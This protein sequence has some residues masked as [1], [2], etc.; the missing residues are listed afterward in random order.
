MNE[1]NRRDFL[2]T[3]GRGAAAMA[4]SCAIPGMNLKS[5]KLNVL[6]IAVDDLRTE[7]GCYGNTRILSPNID[8]IA[9]EGILF[10]R[11]YCQEP[12]CMATR[13]SLLS[14]YRPSHS[15][16]YN[17]ESLDKLVP[18]ALTLNKYFAQKGYDIWASG[19]IYHHKVDHENQFGDQ[20]VTP[21]GKWE[22]RGYL[23]AEAIAQ[24]DQYAEEYEN[25]RGGESSGR[26][27]AFE[28]PDVPD[29]AYED[30]ARTELAI[31]QLEKFKQ[32][33]NPFFMAVGFKKPHLPFNAPQKYWDMY[34]E[35]DIQLANNPFL[36]KGAT[37]FT[38]YNFEELR[39]YNGIPK[40]KASLPDEL[41]RKLIH[42][43]YACVTYIDTQI[44]MLLDE[45]DR[46][47]LRDNTVI[48][49]WGDHGWKLGEH[50]MWCKH[51]PFELDCHAPLIFSAPGMKQ[52]GVRTTA[53]S[54]FVDIY[55]TLCEL[56]GLE[57]PEHL[58]GDSLVPLFRQPDRQWKNAAFTMWPK[59]SRTNPQKAIIG[60]SIK[61]D[62]HRYTEWTKAST[63]Q[64]LAK[65]LYDHH[66][67]PNENE[68]IAL[69]PENKMLVDNLSKMLEGGNGW[70]KFRPGRNRK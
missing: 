16:I 37:E 20:W 45:L 51:T 34:D 41:A 6:F 54:E 65:E 14:G 56:C 32:S 64:V 26:G 43:Y 25:I 10:E 9:S 23:S 40:D 29:N 63:G 66:I 62:Q 1:Y 2:K 69:L 28:A 11:A 50:G 44:G 58:E 19:K 42:G 35:K 17:C 55:P 22:G 31:T 52:R 68:N 53:L 60:Y 5:T 36:P 7:L 61:T 49:L 33:K 21:Q 8:R 46:L 4:V 15:Y 38:P 27:P 47:K 70:R 48:V 57:L 12:I 24:V 59:I 30:G 67:D 13:A 3:M 39:N 18:D